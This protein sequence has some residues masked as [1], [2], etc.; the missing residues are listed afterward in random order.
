M[1]KNKEQEPHYGEEAEQEPHYGES[2]DPDETGTGGPAT[3]TTEETGTDTGDAGRAGMRPTG[4][5]GST[6]PT[7]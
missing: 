4:S 3:R 5:G 2:E 6:P 7:P 1:E